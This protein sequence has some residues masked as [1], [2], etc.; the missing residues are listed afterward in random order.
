MRVLRFLLFPFGLIYDGATRLRNHLYDIGY[1][2][3]IEFD[4]SVISVGNLNVGG[5]GK[6]PMIEY[7]IRLLGVQFKVAT[8]SRGY[9][10]K[11]R[12][13][14]LAG[15]EDSA[16]TLG[17]E[18][19]QFYLKFGDKIS[20]SVGEERALAI[21]ELLM[22]KTETDLILLDDAFQ[23]RPVKPQFSIL[24]TGYSNIFFN[25]FI[26]PVGSLREARTGAKR[27][28]V[29]VVTK[30]QSDI[31]LNEKQRIIQS[32]HRYAPGKPVF[33]TAIKYG[34]PIAINQ[35]RFVKPMQVVIVSGIAQPTLFED[36]IRSRFSIIHHFNFADHHHYTV[37][38]LN[39]IQDKVKSSA[40]N[41]VVIITT[42]KDM[43]RLLPFKEKMSSPWY[44]VPIETVFIENGAEFDRTLLQTIKS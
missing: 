28:D 15:G 14:R 3:S 34:D 29:I 43:V 42:E 31:S 7:L 38:D 26:L 1:R 4:R 9:G 16:K 19:F 10:R 21:P 25:D 24:L 35:S 18:P 12:G 5:S 13:F 8:L 44:Y 32:I 23:H 22:Q 30:C 41:Q 11:T 6:T 17:D 40:S 39:R 20:V 37:E 36:F 27:A 2:R 33:F